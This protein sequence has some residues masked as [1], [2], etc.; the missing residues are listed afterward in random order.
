ME[1]GE[2]SAKSTV[3]SWKPNKVFV[4]SRRFSTKYRYISLPPRQVGTVA[5]CFRVGVLPVYDSVV[6]MQSPER[7][8]G[9]KLAACCEVV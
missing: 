7:D 1:S 2:L 5:L 4:S 3:V 9:T 6:L 8:V